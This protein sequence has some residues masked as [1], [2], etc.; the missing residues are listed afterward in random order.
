MVTL[1]VVCAALISQGN[2]LIAQRKKGEFKGMW[3]F[4]GGKIEP[5]ELPEEA[6]KREI[7]EELDIEI[8][9]KEK[10]HRIVY[11]YPNFIL[12]MDCFISETKDFD[13]SL[14]DH[15]DIQWIELSEQNTEEIKWCPADKHVYENLLRFFLLTQPHLSFHA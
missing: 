9:I 3:E 7:L 13:I 6:L 10:F 12:D 15:S 11:E 1:K 2:L 8:N 14:S 4:P 5:G